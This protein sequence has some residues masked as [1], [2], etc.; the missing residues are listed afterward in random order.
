[1]MQI[2]GSLLGPGRTPTHAPRRLAGEAPAQSAVA[3]MQ[4]PWRRPRAAGTPAELPDDQRRKVRQRLSE[5]CG[6]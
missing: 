1:M 6:A 4:D 3:I 5:G 2:A